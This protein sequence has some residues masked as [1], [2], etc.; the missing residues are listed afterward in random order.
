[1]KTYR[2]PASTS[3]PRAVPDDDG[4]RDSLRR[5]DRREQ[6]GVVANRL[7]PRVAVPCV[8]AHE[9]AEVPF[10]AREELDHLHAGDRFL[11]VGVDAGNP[12]ANRSKRLANLEAKYDCTQREYGHHGERQQGQLGVDAVECHR[13]TDHLDQVC[14]EGND[15]CGEHLRDVLDIVGGS[16]HE[17]THREAIEES[18]M[19]ALDVIE[20]VA[21]QV[22]HCAVAG[23]RHQQH[24]RE[25]Q[26]RTREDRTRLA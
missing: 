26:H 1:M 11:D 25:L 8:H 5:L 16:R 7:L 19:Q 17:A 3:T 13:E 12:N 10:L 20:D 6:Q 18:Q 4:D 9:L 2:T 24:V 14:Y 23:R 21:P 15:A 22:S